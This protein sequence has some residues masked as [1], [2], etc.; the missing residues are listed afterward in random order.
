MS[1]LLLPYDQIWRE[2]KF[3]D[4]DQE[5]WWNALSGSFATLLASSEYT[6]TDQLYYLRWFRRSILGSLGP[7]P[8]LGKPHYAASF[9][10]D[11]SPLEYSLN[12]KE[13]RIGQTVRFTIEPCSHSSGTPSDLLNQRVARDVLS[14]VS[15]D[16]PGV[17]LTRF[18]ILHSATLVPNELAEEA[19][20]KRPPGYPRV[21][22][23]IAFDLECGKVVA[24]A[25]FAPGLKAFLEGRPTH[26]VAFDAI[27]KC[28]GPSGSYEASIKVMEE[29][30]TSFAPDK[31]PHVSLVS[32]DCI[33][34]T[35]TSR[36]K[37]YFVAATRTLEQAE[38]AFSLGGKLAS[39]HIE[40][41]LKV[42]R[43]F[44]HHRFGGD[45]SDPNLETAEVLP[46]GSTC[47]FTFEMRPGVEGQSGLENMEVKMHMPAASVGDTDEEICEVMS[48]WFK[49]HEHR[50]LAARYLSNL[51]AAFPRHDFTTRGRLTHTWI[52][53]THT[54]KT[55][56]YM[57]MY[58]T[59][60]LSEFFY[61][62]EAEQLDR[63]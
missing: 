40:S 43:E 6:E 33:P 4:Q 42:I 29:F 12:W 49:K 55:G 1:S 32:N 27:R 18:D 24:K 2:I 51:E 7:R 26:D 61:M 62:P 63:R 53:L 31:A 5:F 21:R 52:S 13:K 59:P 10:Y 9:T 44:W 58:Y 17:D 60:K 37:V 45:T 54:E 57:T 22:V 3:E 36:I 34:D 39:L 46:E 20:S 19:L 30:L 28:A 50:P 15:Q 35:A 14:Q 8:A 23:L 16:I 48:S 38:H 47:T 11:G 56:I 41:S 25:Y